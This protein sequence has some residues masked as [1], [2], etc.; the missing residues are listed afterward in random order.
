MN[1][2][3]HCPACGREFKSILDYPVVRILSFERLP[4]PEA[5]DYLS[6]AA[7]AKRLARQRME[8]VDPGAG[9]HEGINMTPAIARAC[10]RSEVQDYLNRLS[11]L[12]G[13]EVVPHQL[14]PS[15]QVHRYFKWAYPISD[16]G[17]YLSLSD[18]DAPTGGGRTAEVRV[19]CVGPNFGSAGGPTLQP[20]GAIARLRY[21]GLLVEGFR[22]AGGEVNESR[23]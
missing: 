6:A 15:L 13:Q 11:T 23:A 14:L 4:I 8:P 18:S 2:E 1:Q 20:L 16:T 22:L 10:G 12:P 19:H 7:A 5:V 3:H 21:Q 17:I 9:W